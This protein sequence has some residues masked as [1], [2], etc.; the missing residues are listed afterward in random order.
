MNRILIACVLAGAF[1][2]CSS[3]T[4][5]IE[6]SEFQRSCSVDSDCVAIYE[7]TIGCCGL[8]CPN[9]AV[10]Q[11]GYSAYETAV[12]TRTPTCSPR[13]PCNY[14]RP[15]CRGGVACSNGTCTFNPLAPDASAAD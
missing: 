8:G 6:A 11:V 7:G 2:G 5:S 13:P 14:S 1:G 10:N 9:A 12:S 3:E 15:V 4:H